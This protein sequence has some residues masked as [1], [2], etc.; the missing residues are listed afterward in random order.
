DR[1]EAGVDARCGVLDA[2][3]RCG[4]PRPGRDEVRARGR[5]ARRG[6]G[7]RPLLR[8]A[9]AFRGYGLGVISPV[10]EALQ[11]DP[12]VRLD[13]AKTAGRARGIELVDFGMGD[14][15]EPTP[16]FIQRALTEA[17]PLTA[18]YPRAPGLPEL[19]AAI[20]GWLSTRFGVDVDPDRELIPTYGSK[21]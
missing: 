10:L 5:R 14:P 9:L 20:A 7:A 15:V 2:G 19:R 13:G 3:P 8:R 12:F 6:R 18:G 21:E 4:E 11:T 16:E 1:A 17:L